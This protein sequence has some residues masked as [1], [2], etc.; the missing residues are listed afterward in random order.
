MN[1]VIQSLLPCS[2]L[3][4]LL[5]HCTTGDTARPFYTGTFCVNLW[6]LPA[7]QSSDLIF[8]I[9]SRPH[10]Y[11]YMYRD[12]YK[13]MYV[14]TYAHVYIYMYICTHICIIYVMRRIYHK[15]FH[16]AWCIY[17]LQH[18]RLHRRLCLAQMTRPEDLQTRV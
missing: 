16:V 2:A 5:S 1:V 4:Q 11:T 12:T 7:S 17:S 6:S 9:S 10:I 18:Q 15:A 14:Y 13:Y 8:S 3:M